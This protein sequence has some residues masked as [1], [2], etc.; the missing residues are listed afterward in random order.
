M[1][2]LRPRVSSKTYL[3][4]RIGP[5]LG[6]GIRHRHWTHTQCSG[7]WSPVRL[8]YIL[9]GGMEGVVTTAMAEAAVVAV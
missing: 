3:L 5:I 4:K 9:N 6:V 7:I 8:I 2:V 1:Y